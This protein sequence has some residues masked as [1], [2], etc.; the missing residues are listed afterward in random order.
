MK[1]KLNSVLVDDQD[2]ALKFYTEVLG[3]V[4]KRD[5]PLGRFKWLTVASPEGPDETSAFFAGLL[6]SRDDRG[7]LACLTSASSKALHRH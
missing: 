1:I 4:K 5:I 2:E 3:F 7:P 6:I